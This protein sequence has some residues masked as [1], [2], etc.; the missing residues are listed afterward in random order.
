VAVTERRTKEEIGRFS[1]A[2]EGVLW[3]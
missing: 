1:E 2:L 3:N